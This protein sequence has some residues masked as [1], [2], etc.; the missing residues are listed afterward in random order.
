MPGVCAISLLG[1]EAFF[2]AQCVGV[3]A[4]WAGDHAVL[5]RV[6]KGLTA[7]AVVEKVGRKVA[8]SKPAAEMA[9]AADVDGD[10]SG[11]SSSP[12]SVADQISSTLQDQCPRLAAEDMAE[13][14][15]CA[16]QC[17]QVLCRMLTYYFLFACHAES[18]PLQRLSSPAWPFS[19]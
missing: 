14:P 10:A 1:W 3:L 8:P 5:F 17:S 16:Q 12:L 19:W 2:V 7:S 9:A 18:S 11:N 4:E 13:K 6:S 15:V